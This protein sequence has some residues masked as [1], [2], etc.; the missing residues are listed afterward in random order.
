MGPKSLP[1]DNLAFDTAEEGLATAVQDRLDHDPTCLENHSR[2]DGSA[3][4]SEMEYEK[5]RTGESIW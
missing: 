5:N 3:K 2:L 4:A 1:L